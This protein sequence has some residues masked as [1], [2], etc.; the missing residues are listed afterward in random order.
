MI[1]GYRVKADTS[2]QRIKIRS[3]LPP[4]PAPSASCDWHFLCPMGFWLTFLIRMKSLP[5]F[6]PQDDL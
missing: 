1:S 3:L 4:G 5:C 2:S 6:A